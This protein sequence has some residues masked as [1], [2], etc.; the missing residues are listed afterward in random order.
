MDSSNERQQPALD[1]AVPNFAPAQPSST[2]NFRLPD[3]WPDQPE[4]WFAMAEAQ[5]RL[6]CVT[7]NVDKYCHLLLALPKAS[8]R[9]VS[10]LVT[11]VPEDDSYENVKAVLLSHHVLSD[12]QRV[13]LMPD[14]CLFAHHR[15]PQPYR[16][17]TGGHTWCWSAARSF[18]KSR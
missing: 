17:P 18:S 14:L 3:F 6:R 12:Y 16:R 15:R 2:G 8:Y 10:H 5:F 1:P 4:N 7:S 13:E 11:Q 9:L